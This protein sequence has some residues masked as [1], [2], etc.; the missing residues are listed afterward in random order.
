MLGTCQS[1]GQLAREKRDIKL[2]DSRKY[3]DPRDERDALVSGNRN[4]KKENSVVEPLSKI[5][6][7]KG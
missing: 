6:E 7:R 3:T 1:L 4:V 2:G 5:M